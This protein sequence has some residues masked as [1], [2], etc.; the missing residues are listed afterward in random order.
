MVGSYR[1]ILNL[2]SPKQYVE[3]HHFKLDIIWKAVHMMTPGCF[4]AS[5]DLKDA[6]YSVHIDD[7][8]LKYLKFSWKGNLY[9]F[10]CFANGLAFC[11][12]K[13]TKLLKPVYSTLRMKGPLAVGYVDDSYLQA[14]GFAHCV[15]NIIDTITLLI[16]LGLLYTLTNQFCTP[17]NDLSSWGL[18]WTLSHTWES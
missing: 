15:H 11:P 14:A 9:Q 16:I 1:T 10:T 6:Y 12:G 17:L 5:I 2:K 3:Y 18:C 13:F 7:L 4:M 8:H